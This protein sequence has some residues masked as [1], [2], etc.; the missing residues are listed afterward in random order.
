M[1]F[2]YFIEEDSMNLA[3]YIIRGLLVAVACLFIGELYI[4]HISDF[5]TKYSSMT[6]Y[7]QKGDTQQQMLSD[8]EE[9]ARKTEVEVFVVD[10]GVESNVRE[11][12]TIYGT[13]GV[14]PFLEQDCDLKEGEFDSL[15]L[16]KTTVR[17]LSFDQIPDLTKIEYYQAIGAESDIV[18][19][20]QEL[21]DS[22]AGAFPE[23]GYDASNDAGIV[24]GI[25]GI[26]LALFLLSTL[27][28]IALLKKEGIIRIVSGERLFDFARRK[29]LEDAAGYGAV[30]ATVLP[31]LCLVT[32]AGYKLGITILCMAV[33]L[34]LNTAMYGLL[35]ITNYKRDLAGRTNVRPVLTISYFY[36]CCSMVVIL[37]ILSA[38]AGLVYQGIDCF[39][40]KGFFEEQKSYSYIMLSSMDEEKWQ[41]AEQVWAQLYQRKAA[42]RETISLVELDDFRTGESR[43]IYADRGALPYLKETIPSLQEKEFQEGYT[44]ILSPKGTSKEELEGAKECL[45]SYCGMETE[46]KYSSYRGQADVIA[47]KSEDRIESVRKNNPIILLNCEGEAHL[48][49][50]DG[51]ITQSAMYQ[52]RGEEWERLLAESDLEGEIA[53]KTG[54]YENYQ[55]QWKFLKRGMTIGL[56]LTGIALL[57][58]SL[59]I[60]IILRYE[61]YV[62]AEELALK[63]IFG[64]RM[65]ERIAKL[66]KMTVSCSGMILVLVSVITSFLEKDAILYILLSG[67]LLLTVELLLIFWYARYFDRINVQKI[68]KGGLL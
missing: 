58:E 14:Q 28:R 32:E 22:Y 38:T 67:G 11:V 45:D 56:V 35:L 54:V 55:V 57:M 60:S 20:K 51:Y 47:V 39:R 4:W 44:Y 41:T 34:I 52:F 66:L 3:K 26:T 21:V 6:F 17:F 65:M 37:L 42:A 49:S 8:L 30:F 53:Y 1:P 31:L 15:F 36:K 62:N 43:Y 50:V 18:R 48:G 59:M 10:H 5:E 68:L 12:V 9:A 27:Y 33:F 19:F 7:L 13:A 29:A 2:C 40:Q 46:T 23:E 63:K 64:Y 24:A 25:W 16:G 61:Y